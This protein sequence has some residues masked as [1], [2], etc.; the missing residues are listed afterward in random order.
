MLKIRYKT[1]NKPVITIGKPA[2]ATISIL[3][4]KDK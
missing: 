2:S 4:W 1:L 3:L